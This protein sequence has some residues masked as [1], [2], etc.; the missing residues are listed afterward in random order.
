MDSSAVIS[1]NEFDIKPRVEDI[2]IALRFICAL[3]LYLG[4]FAQDPPCVWAEY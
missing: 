4:L 1:R 3:S 2:K